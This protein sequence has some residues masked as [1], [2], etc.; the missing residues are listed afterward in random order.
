[1]NSVLRV[2]SAPRHY[3][4]TSAHPKLLH[5]TFLEYAAW[6]VSDLFLNK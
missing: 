6:V 1:M 2:V 4:F 3:I 5:Y